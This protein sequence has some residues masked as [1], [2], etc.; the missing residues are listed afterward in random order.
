M[1]ADELVHVHRRSNAWKQQWELLTHLV[2]R[3]FTLRYTG[4][5]LGLLWSALIPLSQLGVLVFVFERV[6]PLGIEAYPAFVFCALVPWTWF[7]NAVGGAASL[8]LTHQDLLRRPRCSPI[9]LVLTHTLSHLLAFFVTLPLVFIV[10]AF[11]G[12][13]P[14]PALWMFPVLVAI[15]GILIVGASLL[16]AVWNV[17]Y[18]DVQHLAGLAL[19]LLFYLTPIFYLLPK[20]TQA[21]WL[22]VF[23]PMGSLVEDYRSIFFAGTVPA[24]SSVLLGTIGS[25]VVL[26]LGLWVLNTKQVELFDE[27]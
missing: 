4:S 7:S 6:V 5:V 27:I 8:F 15:Q 20:G 25:L 16:V 18:R 14:S 22:L 1:I 17:F 19:V 13:P 21:T 2:M 11:Y 12:R 9:I 26:C 24:A 23:N 10:L 3:D